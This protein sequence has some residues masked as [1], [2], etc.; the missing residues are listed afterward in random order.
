MNEPDFYDEM[1]GNDIDIVKNNVTLL[2][3][4]NKELKLEIKK[5][6]CKIEKLEELFEQLKYQPGGYEMRKAEETFQKN[7]ELLVSK[8]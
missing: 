3:R 1:F 8:K 4:E 2:S 5:L 6:K 7:A